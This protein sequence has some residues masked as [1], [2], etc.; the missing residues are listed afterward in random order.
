MLFNSYAFLLLFLPITLIGYVIIGRTLGRNAVFGWLVAASLFFYG[1]WNWYFLALLLASLVFN[2]AAGT[3]LSKLDKRPPAKLVLGVALAFNVGFLGYFK[4]KNFFLENLSALLGTNWTFLPVVLPLGISFYTFQKI[5]YLVDSYQGKT[6]GYGF[7]DFCLFVSFFPQL[8]AGPITH[9]GEIMPQF[10]KQDTARAHWD[11]WSVGLTLFVFGLAK[12]VLLAD[13][14]ATFASPVFQVAKNGADFGFTEAWVGVL[15]YTLQLYFDFSGY[16]DMAIGLARLFGI[17]LPMNFN[18]PYQATNIA[19]FWRRWHVT[20]SRFLRDYLYIPL[21]G[22]R[23]GP[24]RK[25]LN[26]FLTMLIGGIWHGA[27]WTFVIWGALHGFYLLTF[28]A[29]REWRGDKHATTPSL[30]GSIAARAVTFLVVVIAWV[31]FRADNLKAATGLFVSMM[32]ANGFTSN[33]SRLNMTSAW[34]TVGVLLLVV[35]LLPNS[36][37]LLARFEPT[38]EYANKDR[39]DAQLGA[40]PPWARRF[41]WKPRPAW[42]LCLAALTVGSILGLSRVSEFIYWQF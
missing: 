26:L 18:S 34:I 36:H 17:R 39:A 25:Y 33:L 6:R 1:W 21:G 9:H 10:R 29:W 13:R 28:H 3:W 32:G 12:K 27:G 19:D 7:R 2:Y 14:L 16:S 30:A 40:I 35:W 24:T 5:A 38:L 11:D 20:L 4:Y 23:R 37:Q 15:A 42:A 31:F 8:I 22:N 41:V